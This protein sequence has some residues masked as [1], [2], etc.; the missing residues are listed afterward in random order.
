MSCFIDYDKEEKWLREMAKEGYQLEDA[1]FRYKFRSTEPE[2]TVIKV[3][4]RHLK[5]H[6][7]FID[8]CTLFEDSG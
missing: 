3:D 8:Y 4:Y 1:S 7:D 2:Y 5:K 6:E